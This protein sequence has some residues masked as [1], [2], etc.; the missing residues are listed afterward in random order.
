MT[1]RSIK[2][3]RAHF[4]KRMDDSPFVQAR[5]EAVKDLKNCGHLHFA[6]VIHPKMNEVFSQLYTA[7][8]R[9]I[10]KSVENAAQKA[11]RLKLTSIVADLQGQLRRV[12]EHF[13]D[14]VGHYE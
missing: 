9:M 3:V 8:D 14:M 12:Q 4:T 6:E 7:F 11:A 2:K 1:L 10:N 5:T 13:T